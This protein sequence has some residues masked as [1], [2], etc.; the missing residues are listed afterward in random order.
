MLRGA[1]LAVVLVG[2]VAS[3]LIT[4]GWR[5]TVTS[6]ATSAWSAPRPRGFNAFAR[7]LDLPRRHPGLQGIGWRMVVSDDRLA[8]FVARNRAD[9]RRPLYY[10]TQF[11]YPR[12]PS[13]SDLGADARAVPTIL[14][15]LEHARDT[16]RTTSSNQTTLPGDFLHAALQTTAPTT[17]VELHDERVGPAAW[18][19]ASPRASGPTAPSPGRRGSPSATGPSYCAPPPYPATRS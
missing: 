2:M 5:R 10:V 6:S 11:S 9:G 18:S 16:G 8:G 3:A 19:P 4:Q 15:T 13:S 17:G 1:A 12:I 7:S 14:A